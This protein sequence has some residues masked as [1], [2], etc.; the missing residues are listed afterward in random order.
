MIW[1][2]SGF[3]ALAV[4]E[5]MPWAPNRLAW[6]IVVDGANANTN[7]TAGALLQ[8]LRTETIGQVLAIRRTQPVGF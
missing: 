3:L 6:R 1:A 2:T 5:H 4:A 7:G 8:H